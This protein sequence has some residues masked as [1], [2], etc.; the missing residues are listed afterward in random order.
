MRRSIRTSTSATATTSR[1][2]SKC[3]SS[4][5]A[6]PELDKSLTV[7]LSDPRGCAVLG[8][9]AKATLTILDDDRPEPEPPPSGLD[10]TFG[11]D[12]KA[13]LASFGGDDSGMALQPDGKIVMVGGR[14]I[15]FVLARF[16]ADGSTRYELRHRRQ[17]DHGHRRRLRTGTRSR[18]RDSAG[19]QDRG[20]RRVELARRG[21]SGTSRSCATTQMARS[22]RPS[23]RAARRSTRP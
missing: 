18:G 17:S 12:G 6:I 22:T 13:T 16:N 5:T 15:D 23:A 9:Q 20:G 14:F 7:T 2:F 11:T 8:T 19:R 3:R 4:S 1:A 21:D 10:E